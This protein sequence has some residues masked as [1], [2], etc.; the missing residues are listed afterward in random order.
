MKTIFEVRK[1]E[2]LVKPEEETFAIIY[3]DFTIL[4]D[5][6]NIMEHKNH[7]YQLKVLE[8]LRKEILQDYRNEF[9]IK[10]IGTCIAF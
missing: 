2:L 4:V 8:N 6:S 5:E 10:F 7:E 1:N 9:V 3:E